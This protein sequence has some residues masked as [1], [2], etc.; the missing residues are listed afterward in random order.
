MTTYYV[1][2]KDELGYRHTLKAPLVDMT[3]VDI[4]DLPSGDYLTVISRG[5]EY[6]ASKIALAVAAGQIALDDIKA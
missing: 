4:I 6:P 2:P 3:G 5:K 1:T